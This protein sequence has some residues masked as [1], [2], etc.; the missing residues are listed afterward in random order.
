MHI[1]KAPKQCIYIKHKQYIHIKHQTVNI[2]KEQTVHISKA[3]KQ[4]IYLKHQ[5]VRICEIPY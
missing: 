2:S 3:P 5:E 4:C 1:S